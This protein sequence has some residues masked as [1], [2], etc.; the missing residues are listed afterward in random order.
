MVPAAWACPGGPGGIHLLPPRAQE[1]LKLTE[2]QK[3]QLIALEAETKAKLENIL[4]PEQ[5]EQMKHMRPQRGGGQGRPAGGTGQSGDSHQRPEGQRPPGHESGPGGMGNARGG[6][7]GGIHLL[8]PRAQEEL[9][10]TE[11][12]KKKLTSLEAETKAKL[13]KILTPEQLEQMKNM[14]PPGGQGGPG[15][16]PGNPGAGNR[17]ARPAGE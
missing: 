2:E 8:P 6:P 16:G 3:K 17:P 10:L 12:Q 1:E 9:K 11:E 13:E 14:R 5:L 15:G 7:S 4:T